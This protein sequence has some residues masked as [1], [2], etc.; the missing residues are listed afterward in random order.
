[1]YFFVFVSWGKG[2]QY[3]NLSGCKEQRENN[4]YSFYMYIICI[5]ALHLS[6]YRV[7]LEREYDE[8]MNFKNAS[9][10]VKCRM[11]YLKSLFGMADLKVAL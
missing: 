10:G 3:T 5:W 11:F 7:A 6:Q 9:M 8:N 4:P 1:M 2:L